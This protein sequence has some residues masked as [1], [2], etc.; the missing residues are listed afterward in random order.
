MEFLFLSIWHHSTPFPFEFCEMPGCLIWV[1]DL[2]SFTAALFRSRMVKLRWMNKKPFVCHTLG[3]F[4]WIFLKL[5]LKKTFLF[6]LQKAQSQRECY[7]KKENMISS[8]RCTSEAFLTGLWMNW[9]HAVCH[10]KCNMWSKVMGD[11]CFFR[12]LLGA[13][14]RR[15][16]YFS[17]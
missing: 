8:S 10:Q 6:S 12:L 4:L 5:F 16:S 11:L 2:C 7:R 17:Q 1:L 15:L 9:K 13:W 14:G 3:T